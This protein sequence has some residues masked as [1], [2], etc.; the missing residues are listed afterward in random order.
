MN[1]LEHK[2]KDPINT[3]IVPFLFPGMIESC[4][5]SIWEHCSPED[6]RLIVIDNACE[7]DMYPRLKDKVHLYIR[8]YRN[9]GCSK[10]WNMGINIT[11]TKYVS[12]MG[13]DTQIIHDDWWEELLDFI[14]NDPDVKDVGIWFCHPSHLVPDKK[15]EAGGGK[16]G[17]HQ[18]AMEGKCDA[19][20]LTDEEWEDTKQKSS[21]MVGRFNCLIIRRD[22]IH[23]LSAGEGFLFN[24]DLYP[25]YWVDRTLRDKMMEEDI[26]MKGLKFPVWHLRAITCQS[27]KMVMHDKG[28]TSPN[29]DLCPKVRR[30][31]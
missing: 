13:D 29:V 11:Q 23:R 10:P 26:P 31:L 20:E 16:E 3:F 19:P 2:T 12:I 24:E 4:V 28:P 1:L 14:E 8:S 25:C 7:E 21:D 17:A 15:I 22:M 30:Y 5:D 6:H 18:A 9:L 27:G